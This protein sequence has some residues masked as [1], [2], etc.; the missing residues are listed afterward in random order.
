MTFYAWC[1]DHGRQHRFEGAPWCT[2]RWVTLTGATEEAALD[3]KRARFRDA[4]FLHHLP[5]WNRSSI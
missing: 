1:F 5:D 2:A 3:D 4:R